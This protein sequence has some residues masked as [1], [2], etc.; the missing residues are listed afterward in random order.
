MTTELSGLASPANRAQETVF[1]EI[2]MTS[3]DLLVGNFLYQVAVI[4]ETAKSSPLFQEK[5]E[6]MF[7][8]RSMRGSSSLI[9]LCTALPKYKCVTVMRGHLFDELEQFLLGNEFCTH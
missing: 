4:T 9:N 8:S 5:L 2:Q 6:S 1:N 7:G 3:E